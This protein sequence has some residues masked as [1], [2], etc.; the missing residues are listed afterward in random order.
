M[1]KKTKKAKSLELGRPKDLGL[2]ENWID[3]FQIKKNTFWIMFQPEKIYKT[4]LTLC[5]TCL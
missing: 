3:L 5:R 4:P 1:K 2:P